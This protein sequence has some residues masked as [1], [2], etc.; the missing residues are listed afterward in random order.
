MENTQCIPC[1]LTTTL[2]RKRSTWRKF[3]TS[4][5]R[6]TGRRR[7]LRGRI[8]HQTSTTRSRIPILYQMERLSHHRS[9]LGKRVSIFQRWKHVA[10]IQNTPSNLM[11]P[12]THHNMFLRKTKSAPILKPSSTFNKENDRLNQN[13][14]YLQ[15]MIDDMIQEY[16]YMNRPL[17]YPR[18]PEPHPITSITDKS[19]FLNQRND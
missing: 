2:C 12:I 5:T 15:T 6:T 13:V 17:K 4:I 7:S 16:Q 14:I 11:F 19:I 10:T 3:S 1:N 8:H 9:N 18:N